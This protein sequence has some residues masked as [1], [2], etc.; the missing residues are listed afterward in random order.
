MAVITVF[1]IS[2]VILSHPLSNQNLSICVLA[3]VMVLTLCFKYKQKRFYIK[4][5]NITLLK[6][7]KRRGM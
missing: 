2:L 7:I 6:Y 1:I 4:I 5:F 3:E